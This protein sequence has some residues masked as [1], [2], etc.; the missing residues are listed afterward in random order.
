MQT[1]RVFLL[2]AFALIYRGYFALAREPRV[3]S[4]G[5]DVTAI[6]GF[7]LILE[8]IISREQ[9]DRLA[10][11]FDPP[12]GTF[13]H[14]EFTDYKAH[15]PETP[16]AI[17]FALPFIKDL[18]QAYKIPA[19]EVANY[20]ADDVIGTLACRAAKENFE[21]FM[22]TPDKDYAQLVQAQ[23]KMYRPNHR[24]GGYQVWGEKEVCENFELS[25]CSQ[26]IDYLA[27]VGDSADN[28]PGCPKIGKKTASKL[29]NTYGSLD[30]VYANIDKE[31]G[32]L[33]ENLIL[34]EESARQTQAL[35][36]ICT[37]VEMEQGLDD[38]YRQEPD[39]EALTTL[40][41]RLEF[42]SSLAKLQRTGAINP[43]EQQ[44]EETKTEDKEIVSSLE[45]GSSLKDTSVDQ[46][47]FGDLFGFVDEDH[48][49][50]QELTTEEL[51][52]FSLIDLNNLA[53]KELS[54]SEEIKDFVQACKDTKRFACSVLTTDL[55]PFKA[56]LVMLV[57]ALSPKDLYSIS[58]PEDK[59]KVLNLL[60]EIK[61]LFLDPDILKIA[62]NLKYILQVLLNYNFKVQLPYHDTMLAH[63][64]IEADKRHGLEELA[65]SYLDYDLMSFENL[66][67]PQKQKDLVL[68]L[69]EKEQL[70]HYASERALT[71]FLLHKKLM[72]DL[73]VCE[74]MKLYEELEMPL[75]DVLLRM[76]RQGVR[77]DL[78][79]LAKLSSQM[80]AE[81]LTLER[82]IEE[83]AGYPLNV[84]SPKQIG[85]L[86]F[87]HL[88]LNSKAKK[89]KSGSY[90]TSEDKLE[91]LRDK[92]PVVAKILAYRGLKKLLSTYI[93][94]L[95]DLLHSDAKLHSTFNQ[96]V[97]ATGRLS[98]S[99]P[100]I[101]NIPIRTKEGR[102]IREAFVPDSEDYIFVSADYSQ[103]ELRLMAHFSQDEELIN[104]F[105][106]GEDVHRATASHIYNVPLNLVTEEMRRAAKMAN[107]GIIYGI[108]AFGLAERLSI[109][110]KE[111][112][113]L[114]EGYFTSYPK[115]KTYMDQVLIDAKEQGYVSTLLGRRRYLP[116]LKN[117]NAVV[118]AYAERNAI[119][120][121]LQGTAADII[122][123][124]MLQLD[125]ALISRGLKS[126]LILQVHDELNLNVAK[127]ELDEVLGLLKDSMQN[128]LNIAVPLDVELGFGANWLEAH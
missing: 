12:G 87:D 59:V 24:G 128:A 22:V 11:V 124:A 48:V 44:I 19:V 13:R 64:L 36:R 29:L 84:N 72:K 34:G 114:I 127:D 32:K 110:R 23:V 8:D 74:Q 97:A 89:T 2:D 102:A 68:R 26:I 57:F 117:A 61:E 101:Q 119:N 81:L 67:A 1:K 99:N 28:L 93:D 21:V 10:V 5:E 125:E 4:R 95:P 112:K 20:E 54:S 80:N 103:I 108:S 79:I 120:A 39:L 38:F 104:A 42:K 51:D 58:F 14:K 71:T 83:V 78:D 55:D 98:S 6:Y 86:L 111:A 118:R 116:D 94:A 60:D 76:E 90:S 18:L 70:V 82:E 105:L 31:K 30:N 66:I 9:P 3:N 15:R 7:L 107:F 121:P 75:L 122:K 25:S 37:D 106:S 100:N 41:E 16:D 123:I 17:R 91:K 115:V 63:Y 62:H 27:F 52:D 46:E 85:E 35:V 56:E 40:Y 109:S 43:L 53:V 50:K 88:N 33:K 113:A 92:H 96:A 45:V 69:V 49:H 65:K 77:L 126:R 73:E 47:D